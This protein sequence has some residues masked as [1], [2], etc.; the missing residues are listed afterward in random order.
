ME[1]GVCKLT[2]LDNVDDD[3]ELNE[4]MARSQGWPADARSEM[5]PRFPKD[6]GLA[7][8]LYGTG[9]VVVSVATRAIL[10]SS[11]VRNTEYLPIQL[12]NHKGRAESA[13]YFIVNPLTVVDCIDQAASVVEF[14]AVDTEMISSC[15]QLVLNEAVISPEE[16]L[17][18][19]KHWTRLLLIRRSLAEKIE[20]AGLT[21]MSFIEPSKYTGLI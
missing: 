15:T 10:E 12:I 4:G 17:F 20:K 1:D 11:G 6:I 5:N 2:S 19:P 9:F 16:V 7:D 14:N 18:R 3:F 13:A 21:C 8:S